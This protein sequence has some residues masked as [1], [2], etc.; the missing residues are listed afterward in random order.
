MT[1]LKSLSCYHFVI[2]SSFIW[3]S[4][5][6]NELRHFCLKDRDI[7]HV[8]SQ[9]RFPV[10][11]FQFFQARFSTLFIR[12]I[13]WRILICEKRAETA[14]SPCRLTLQP[15][16]SGNIFIALLSRFQSAFSLSL[17][18][19]APLKIM[20]FSFFV[21]FFCSSNPPTTFHSL[22]KYSFALKS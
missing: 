2:L 18:I 11:T 12:K 1:E 14:L 9:K 15:T 19:F 21:S 8:L 13:Q 7:C 20:K 4:L 10:I 22:L 17:H 6:R 16:F 5:A 3:F